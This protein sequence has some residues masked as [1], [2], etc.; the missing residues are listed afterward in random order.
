MNVIHRL[1]RVLPPI[2]QV[3]F[4][5]LLVFSLMVL[6]FFFLRV[7][8]DENHNSI[9]GSLGLPG[10][11]ESKNE[12]LKFLGISM[13]GILIALQ[14]LMSYRRAKALE[15]TARAQ[16]D[17]VLKTEQGQRQDRLKNAIE[18]LGHESESVRLGGVYELFQLAED[19]KESR[20]TVLDIL[21]AHIRRTTGESQYR[22]THSWKPSEEVQ[23]L[24]TL[25]FV[26]EH[27]VY[28]GLRVNLQ[29]SWLSGANLSE[30]R[31]NKAILVKAYLQ[32]VCLGNA[33]LE[34]ADL[35]EVQLQ[36]A[37][38]TG[39]NLRKVSLVE[40]HMQR[41]NLSNAK[42]QGSI[43][44]DARL[45]GAILV[46]AHLQE[47]GLNGTYLQAAN[48]TMARM[49][50][51]SLSGAKM[52]GAYL[53]KAQLHGTILRDAQ[54]QGAYLRSAQLHEARFSSIQGLQNY[55]DSGQEIDPEPAQLQ[56][57]S[58]SKNIPS[59]GFV[60]HIREQANQESDLTGA[61]F[62]GGLS[63][64]DIVSITEGLSDKRATELWEKLEFHLGKPESN[65]LPE[66]SYAI[67]GAYIEP[68]AEMW[69]IKYEKAV[70]DFLGDDD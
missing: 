5:T 39:A 41:A 64:A 52:Q 58:S 32:E 21:C 42:L 66:N 1:K 45:H 2:I 51:A 37:D 6:L 28:S 13:G 63:E 68:E 60:D 65:E 54:M 43:L 55:N 8:F 50:M 67:T 31:L 17:A 20:Q 49:Q 3:S 10:N 56:G 62:A 44:N 12:A 15:D 14:A 9:Y 40:S 25:L 57:A 23:S 33:Q 59:S 11:K 38:L 36:K 70:S 22:K 46:G 47:T 18:H 34:G 16:A 35:T 27:D 48:L 53:A 69:I 30:A 61:T 26:Q 4:I 19:T 29:G 7:V 24:L